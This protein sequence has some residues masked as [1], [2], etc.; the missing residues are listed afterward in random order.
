MRSRSRTLIARLD[1][2][3]AAGEPLLALF[4]AE[5]ELL[6]QVVKSAMRGR[7]E[8]PPRSIDG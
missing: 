1:E 3:A 6:D 7:E 5:P 2:T 8:H 4:T